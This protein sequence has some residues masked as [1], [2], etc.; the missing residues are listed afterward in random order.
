MCKR[1]RAPGA[2][3]KCQHSHGRVEHGDTCVGTTWQ[4]ILQSLPDSRVKLLAGFTLPSH[5]VPAAT[6]N[7]PLPPPTDKPHVYK[8]RMYCLKHP[9]KRAL[10][11]IEILHLKLNQREV[12]DFLHCSFVLH[13]LDCICV[14]IPE[15]WTTWGLLSRVWLPTT[16]NRLTSG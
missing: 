8:C 2:V 9:L 16:V 15:N 13:V 11:I 7:Q 1:C 14:L 4:N 6:I 12:H 3:W 5:H 10:S